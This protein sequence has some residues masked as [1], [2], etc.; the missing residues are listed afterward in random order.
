MAMGK[1]SFEQRSCSV[2]FGVAGITRRSI[3]VHFWLHRTF[4]VTGASR[5]YRKWL[6]GNRSWKVSRLWGGEWQIACHKRI[7]TSFIHWFGID[8]PRNHFPQN[9]VRRRSWNDRISGTI[10][11]KKLTR[12][13]LFPDPNWKS[14]LSIQ[15]IVQTL[16][17]THVV[18][19]DVDAIGIGYPIA[20][21]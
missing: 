20:R 3:G 8:L 5:G 13:S 7:C 21:R 19:K 10:C 1:A 12:S 6:S 2:T 16:N 4:L 15:N 14:H 9:K 18:V 11:F 17:L